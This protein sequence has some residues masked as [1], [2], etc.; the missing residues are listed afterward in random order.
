MRLLLI[1]VAVTSALSAQT[2]QVSNLSN[3]D[4]DELEL[5]EQRDTVLKHIRDIHE[6]GSAG[7]CLFT[8]AA[9]VCL[10]LQAQLETDHPTRARVICADDHTASRK[11][12]VSGSSTRLMRE[13]WDWNE[14]AGGDG[15]KRT[16]CA[17]GYDHTTV[18]AAVDTSSLGDLIE[19]EPETFGGPTTGTILYLLANHDFQGH[20]PTYMVTRTVGYEPNFTPGQRVTGDANMATLQGGSN[21]SVSNT[22]VSRIEERNQIA[23]VKA[24][25]VSTD[26]LTT[27]RAHG[28]SVGDEL[29]WS[30]R[31]TAPNTRVDGGEFSYTRRIGSSPLRRLVHSR[32]QKS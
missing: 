16:V 32:W 7:A 23:P 12:D 22:H 9:E 11:V 26:F 5:F 13:G 10:E 27:S 21:D 24:V 15:T 30:Q 17:S 2:Y 8:V 14:S 1:T 29:V 19:L 20:C 25:N 28:F 4:L 31:G 18:Q 6:A 3:Q